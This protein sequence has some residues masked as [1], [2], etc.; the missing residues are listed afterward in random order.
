MEGYTSSSSLVCIDTQVHSKSISKCTCTA[1]IYSIARFSS[2]KRTNVPSIVL[3]IQ[4]LVDEYESLRQKNRFFSCSSLTATA[5][6]YWLLYI[7]KERRFAS[8]NTFSFFLFIEHADW[9]VESSILWLTFGAVRLSIKIWDNSIL[10]T[11]RQMP[12]LIIKKRRKETTTDR[13]KT[14][15]DFL[16]G[17]SL[18]NREEQRKN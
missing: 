1:S 7:E 15:R 4:S 6:I 11:F 13:R 8:I 3:S 18:T 2:K 9:H 17:K 16:P 12:H 10:F 5:L 14:R